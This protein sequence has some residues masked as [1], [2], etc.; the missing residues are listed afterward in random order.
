MSRYKHIEFKV[1]DMDIVM[2][3][4]T[5]TIYEVMKL[6]NIRYYIYTMLETSTGYP[7]I[8]GYIQTNYSYTLR[9]W[10]KR[11]G[12]RGSV[13]PLHGRRNHTD[14]VVEIRKN[15]E[16]GKNVWEG[17]VYVHIGRQPS[18]RA[19]DTILYGWM[20]RKYIQIY[21]EIMMNRGE[22]HFSHNTDDIW[23]EGIE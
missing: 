1:Y 14:L 9:S 16:R 11:M 12:C 3:L 13:V 5:N 20:K 23:I 6:S 19:Y 4:T 17:G 22:Y 2:N 21:G 18:I 7:Y 15:K 8:H 10:M